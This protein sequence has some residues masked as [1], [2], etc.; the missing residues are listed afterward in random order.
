MRL[1]LSTRNAPS[2]LQPSSFLQTIRR[3][4][5]LSA[6]IALLLG[7]GG[8]CVKPHL[9]PG[10]ESKT[11]D[12]GAVGEDFGE[13]PSP[14][15]PLETPLSRVPFLMAHDAAT[16][17]RHDYSLLGEVLPGQVQTQP[18]G[19]FTALLDCG[20]RAFDLRP[21]YTHDRQLYMHHGPVTVKHRME[22]ALREIIDWAGRHREALVLVYVSHCG[23]G[24]GCTGG[25]GRPNDHC[26]SATADLLGELGITMLPSVDISYGEAQEEGRLANGG[27]LLA[28]EQ[29]RENYDESVQFC[30]GSEKKPSAFADLFAY[31]D[32]IAAEAPSGREL[33]ITQAHWQDP[34]T[35][36]V[37]GCAETVLEMESAS[38]LNREVA[39]RISAG[40]WPHINLLEVDNACDQGIELKAALEGRL[41]R[42]ISGETKAEPR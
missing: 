5:G 6:G 29:A 26:D 15:I 38:K 13:R 42:R 23:G 36:L 27:H 19:G 34:H 33:V 11:G 28:F 30:A 3:T 14:G 18:E 7:G 41:A 22:D 10:P 12:R 32:R 39:R 40:Q 4:A 20:V 37:D 24:V 2:N 25:T 21:C 16:T 1:N 17:Y 9:P 31:M 35:T 8:A